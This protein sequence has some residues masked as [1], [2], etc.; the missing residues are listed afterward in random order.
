MALNHDPRQ[1]HADRILTVLRIPDQTVVARI[2][3]V[4]QKEREYIGRWKIS[5]GGKWI[6]IASRRST[7]ICDAK[8]G[9]LHAMLPAGEWGSEWDSLAIS[10]NNRRL[11]RWSDHLLEIWNLQ[12]QK[13]V[14]QVV[15]KSDVFLFAEFSRSDDRLFV[16]CDQSRALSVRSWNTRTGN[17]APVW[18]VATGQRL[19]CIAISDGAEQLVLVDEQHQGA[20]LMKVVRTL[21]PRWKTKVTRNVEGTFSPLRNRFAFSPDGK[22]LATALGRDVLI[23]DKETGAFKSKI[24]THPDIIECISYSPDGKLLGTGCHD[25]AVRVWDAPTHKLLNALTAPGQHMATPFHVEFSPD[26]KKSL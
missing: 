13:M 20:F 26:N 23:L 4:K 9:R 18:P 3:V 10:W 21:E 22:S 24:P 15:S 2:P 14:V 1:A 8:S 19:S 16:V 17:E 5:P 6:A 11:A 25:A 12:T 7:R